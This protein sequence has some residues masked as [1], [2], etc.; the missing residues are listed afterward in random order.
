MDETQK[1]SFRQQTVA[2][3]ELNADGEYSAADVVS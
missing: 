2:L 3:L 1:W